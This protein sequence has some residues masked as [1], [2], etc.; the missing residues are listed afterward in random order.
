MSDVCEYYEGQVS[1]SGICSTLEENVCLN[2]FTADSYD[3]RDIWQNEDFF[4][5]KTSCSQVQE[6]LS[7]E[8]THCPQG[9]PIMEKTKLLTGTFINTIH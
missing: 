6:K 9:A 7:K 1:N 8:L 3:E 2:F 4:L 5:R